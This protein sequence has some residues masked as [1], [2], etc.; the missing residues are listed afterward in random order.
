MPYTI[1][2]TYYTK[3]ERR[4]LHNLGYWID[5]DGNR[6]YVYHMSRERVEK[7]VRTLGNWAMQEDD[8]MIYLRN[9][10]IYLHVLNMVFKYDLKSSYASMFRLAWQLDIPVG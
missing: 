6:L 8:P 1:T 5:R 2:R 7:L 9:L 3:Q 4:N 10:P